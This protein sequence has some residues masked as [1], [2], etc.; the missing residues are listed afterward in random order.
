MATERLAPYRIVHPPNTDIGDV[1]PKVL[2]DV[3]SHGNFCVRMCWSSNAP[4]SLNGSHLS[5]RFPPAASSSGSV[6]VSRVLDPAAGDTANFVIQSQTA[7]TNS[8]SSS[9]GWSGPG[10][11]EPIH[12]SA[13]NVSGT[14]HDNFWAFLSGITLGIAGGALIAILQEFVAPLRRRR[15]SGHPV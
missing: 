2:T 4:V 9:W 13:V 8:D 3:T 12:L 15:D 14:R 1:L 7:P 10:I 11:R 5:A 6:R